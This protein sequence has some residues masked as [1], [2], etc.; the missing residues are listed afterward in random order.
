MKTLIN[1]QSDLAYQKKPTP[2][3]LYP[4]LDFV[5]SLESIITNLQNGVYASEYEAQVEFN[6]LVTAA[7]DFHLVY[8]ADI[9]YVFNWIRTDNLISVSTDGTSLPN[10]YDA[11]DI[12][13][14]AKINGTMYQASPVVQINDT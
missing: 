5:G 1:F 8:H 3:W 11:I 13:A 10:V 14:L 9:L 4:G 6:S 12:D 7:Y 2:G